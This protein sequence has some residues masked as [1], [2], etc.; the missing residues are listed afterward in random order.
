MS[1]GAENVIL[2]SF[3][4]QYFLIWKNNFKSTL[5]LNISRCDMK[6]VEVEFPYFIIPMKILLYVA[7]FMLTDKSGERRQGWSSERQGE[8][9]DAGSLVCGLIKGRLA[10]LKSH[11]KRGKEVQRA[12]RRD[13]SCFALEVT[14]AFSAAR[15]RIHFVLDTARNSICTYL[16]YRQQPARGCHEDFIIVQATVFASKI[17]I[18]EIVFRNRFFFFSPHQS[19]ARHAILA[20]WNTA[21]NI[22]EI[23]FRW[24]R[25]RRAASITRHDDLSTFPTLS[26][27]QLKQWLF[28]FEK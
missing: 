21:F 16:P 11:L 28:S 3:I 1:E 10:W 23:I 27:K 24:G 18:W 25:G 15:L 22:L 9:S 26:T 19:P 14:Y 2:S 20:Q 17:N 12:W 6:L 8:S 5:T 4:E 7:D 13:W